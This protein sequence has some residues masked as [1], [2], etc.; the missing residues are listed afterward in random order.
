[1]AHNKITNFSTF[2]TT[3]RPA[4]YVDGVGNYVGFNDI[5]GGPHAGIVFYGNEHVIEYNYLSRVALE[6]ADVGAIYTARDW[7]AQ[8]TVIRFNV[9]IGHAVFTERF[10]G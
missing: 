7:T 10:Q 1:M 5:S 8:G 4:V 9:V 3:Y 6:T 2:S